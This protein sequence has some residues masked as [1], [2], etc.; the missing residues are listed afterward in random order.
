[1]L[2]CAALRCEQAQREL[3]AGEAQL[4]LDREALRRERDSLERRVDALQQVSLCCK[5]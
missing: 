2:R 1:M 3:A 4:A 5:F